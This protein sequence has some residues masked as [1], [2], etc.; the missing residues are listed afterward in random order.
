VSLRG[1]GVI[2]KNPP[3]DTLLGGVGEY[4]N[5][6]Y[7]NPGNPKSKPKPRNGANPGNNLDGGW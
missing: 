1:L 4:P 2:L 3:R 5:P 6:E 7:P